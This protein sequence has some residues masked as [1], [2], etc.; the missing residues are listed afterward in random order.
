MTFYEISRADRAVCFEP[1]F[2]IAQEGHAIISIT[3]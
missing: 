2:I 3:F 1:V